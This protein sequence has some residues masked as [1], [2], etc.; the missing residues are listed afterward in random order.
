LQQQVVG[1][2]SRWT[3]FSTARVGGTD[4]SHE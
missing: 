3:P 4:G 2:L 1:G